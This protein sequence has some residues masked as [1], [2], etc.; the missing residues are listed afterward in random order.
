[1]ITTK[2]KPKLAITLKFPYMKL[3]CLIKTIDTLKKEY[4]NEHT[5]KFDITVQL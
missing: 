2:K 3:D 1:M 5:L 4:E